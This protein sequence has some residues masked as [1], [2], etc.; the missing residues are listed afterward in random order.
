MKQNPTL[1]LSSHQQ[2]SC[3]FKVV[4]TVPL[5]LIKQRKKY[6]CIKSLQI[7]I[8]QQIT[9]HA[10]TGIGNLSHLNKDGVTEFAKLSERLHPRVDVH[11]ILF[12]YV[13]TIDCL[14]G[15]WVDV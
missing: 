6:L 15:V 1:L 12:S 4:H 9:H 8:N 3:I 10:L 7:I 13:K 2:C 11:F 14:L 5:T